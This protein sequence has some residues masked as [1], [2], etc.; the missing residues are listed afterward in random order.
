MRGRRGSLKQVA[1]MHDPWNPSP[2]EIREW[3]YTPGAIE[4]CQD[5]DLALART[6][7][8]RALLE[9]TSD[10]A[11][12]AR[13]F[14]LSVL[15]SVVGDAVRTGFRSTPR[16]VIE[17][18]V[19]RAGEYR[20]PDLARW[21]ARSEEVLRRPETLDYNQWCGGLLARNESDD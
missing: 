9:L 17:G 4:P 1:E 20:H 2:D 6:R 14:I 15:Y 8:E 5:W 16:P 7:H 19:R 11:C 3:A 10:N 21:Q 18:F 13:R 12:P